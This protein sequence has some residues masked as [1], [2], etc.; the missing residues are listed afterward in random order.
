MTK[1]A[2]I[3]SI[4]WSSLSFFESAFNRIPHF[5]F[6]IYIYESAVS[7]VGGYV[8]DK[9]KFSEICA[10]AFLL[11]CIG[12]SMSFFS[13]NELMVIPYTIF[14]DAGIVTLLSMAAGLPVFYCAKTGRTGILPGFG[15]SGVDGQSEEINPPDTVKNRTLAQR[16]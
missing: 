10:A 3:L 8:I 2:G 1:V 13:Q 15:H 9:Y 6:F 14:P 16:W 5:L 11:I 4:Y 7:I 12:Q